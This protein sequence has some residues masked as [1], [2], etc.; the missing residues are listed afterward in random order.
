MKRIED[1]GE[2]EGAIINI[3]GDPEPELLS[4]L[5]QD[6]VGRA[7]PVEFA[8]A[9][10]RNIMAGQES[11]GRSSATPNEGWAQ[12]VFGEPDVDRL[13]TDVERAIRLDEPEPGRRLAGAS[14]PPRRALQ[15]GSMRAAS[16]LSA[17]AGP[18][19]I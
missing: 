3:T 11:I 12:T 14:Q 13:W 15:P 4:D 6:R 5:D 17:I 18:A 7:R 1:L 10:L 9:N 19:P 2:E 16:T 8:E